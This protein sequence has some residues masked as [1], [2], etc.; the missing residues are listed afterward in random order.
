MREAP[1]SSTRHED[2]EG[3]RGRIYG[4][5]DN[6]DDYFEPG[7]FQRIAGFFHARPEVDVLCGAIRIV[8]GNG[9]ARLRKLI[10]DR[11]DLKRFVAGVSVV[12]QQGTFF[13]RRAFEHSGGFNLKNRTCWDGELL[14]DFA[15]KGCP[16]RGN[17]PGAG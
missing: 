15:L 1:P 9:K 14:V 3:Y 13:R 4:Q 6:A 7:A 5:Y 2:A 10:A 11:F 16:L 12:G 17:T 8:D